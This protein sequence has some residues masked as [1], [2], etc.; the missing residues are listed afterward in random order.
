MALT[1]YFGVPGSGKTTQAAAIVYRNSKRGVTTYSNVPIAGAVLV[2]SAD[3]GVSDISN[4]ELILDEASI[5]YNSRSYKTMPKTAIEWFKLSRHYGISNIHVFSQSYEDMDITLRRLQTSMYLLTRTLL[6]GVFL[7]R[8]ISVRISIDRDTHQI[9]ERYG[10]SGLPSLLFGRKYWSMF[11]SWSA[12]SL[13]E[14]E[15]PSVGVPAGASHRDLVRHLRDQ[16]RLR[17]QQRLLML[18]VRLRLTL[19]RLRSRLSA[20][21]SRKEM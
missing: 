5:E 15:F 20:G 4:G 7:R 11:D 6:P 16:S 12:P 9:A 8:R 21:A 19:M 3:I 1:I 10:W 18:A 2:S 14:R 13:P 17:R